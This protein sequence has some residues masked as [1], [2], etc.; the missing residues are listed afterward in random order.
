MG[1]E[2]G[3][4][5]RLERALAPLGPAPGAW[6]Y[7][8]LAAGGSAHRT[9]LVERPD[10]QWV[11]K[12]R[13]DVVGPQL[14]V[15]AEAHATA[16]AAA[17]RLAPRVVAHDAAAGTLV[18][19]YL[20]DARSWTVRDARRDDNVVRLAALLRRLHALPP[21]LPP[22]A[23]ARVAES[24]V[25]RAGTPTPRAARRA[26][27]L[28]ARARRFEARHPPTVFCHNDLA[29]SNVLDAGDALVLI[30]FEYAVSSAPIL[31]LAGAAMMNGYDAHARGRLIEAY[32]GGAPAPFD[33]AELDETVRM[34]RLLAWFWAG[35][36]ARGPASPRLYARLR[37]QIG[38]VLDA[39]E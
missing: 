10:G 20:P 12:M 24:Y 9:Y 33:A 16:L 8:A 39:E 17:A 19:E 32:Y 18:I 15:A 7:R 5:A 31:D 3:V 23:L 4:R 36:N 2:G 28:D 35:A 11:V 38:A 34:L 13:S 21:E 29:A 14:D 26:I 37:R 1:E 6:T 27:E 30:D 25:R 22:Y